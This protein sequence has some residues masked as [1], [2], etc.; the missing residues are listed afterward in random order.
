MT[1]MVK[2]LLDIDRLEQGSAVINKRRTAL[3][4]VVDEMMELVGPTASEADQELTCELV[5]PLPD[6]QI[7]PDMIT[8]VVVNLIENAIKHTPEEGSCFAARA[9][10]R[11]RQF[12]SASAIPG[13]A[14]RENHQKEIFDKYYRISHADA[15]NGVGLGLAFCRLAVEAHGGKIW[16][17]N[18]ARR[19][20]VLHLHAAAR[21]HRAASATAAPATA[22]A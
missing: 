1:R 7:D 19:R 6:V 12:I 15:P 3:P 18:L 22:Q 4:A 5:E 2:G 9:A 16:V 14:S 11:T 8:R 20:R 10:S 21:T 17:E 13:P